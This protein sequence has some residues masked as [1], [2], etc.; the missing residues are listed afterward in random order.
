MEPQDSDKPR[1]GYG[2]EETP[3]SRY[4]YEQQKINTHKVKL[5]SALNIVFQLIIFLI[6]IWLYL[7]TT[8]YLNAFPFILINYILINVFFFILNYIIF[9]NQFTT[10]RKILYS[11]LVFLSI[12]VLLYVSVI[13]LSV[14]NGGDILLL[15]WCIIILLDVIIY[16]FAKIIPPIAL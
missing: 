6:S 8:L 5:P 7:Q 12:L 1:R 4:S 15:S 13:V 9:R 2:L 11:C 16:W 3:F 10:I 14:G